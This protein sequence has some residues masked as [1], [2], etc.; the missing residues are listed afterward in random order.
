[1]TSCEGTSG[2]AEKVLVK[3]ELKKQF[4]EVV[5]LLQSETALEGNNFER[6]RFRKRQE[7]K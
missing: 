5:S 3:T 6:V 2:Q 1:M 7:S 4:N